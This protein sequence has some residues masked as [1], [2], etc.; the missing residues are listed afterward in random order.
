MA[1]GRNPTMIVLGHDDR[2]ARGRQPIV[3]TKACPRTH[4]RSPLGIDGSPLPGLTSA[5]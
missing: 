3:G 4:I 1:V 5:W 2:D